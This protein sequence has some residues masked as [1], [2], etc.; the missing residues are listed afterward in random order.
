[1]E[2]SSMINDDKSVQLKELLLQL[3]K[4]VFWNA[5]RK[6]IMTD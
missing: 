1:M 4:A 6:L 5:L 3:T 2:I